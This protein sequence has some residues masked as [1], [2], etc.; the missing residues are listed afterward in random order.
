MN[1]NGGDIIGNFYA[2]YA[3]TGSVSDI[4]YKKEVTPVT[5]GLNEIMRLNPIKYKYNMP[6]ESML[7]NDP[8]FFL[9]FSA[10]EVQG[11]IPEAVHEKMESGNKDG[12]LAITYDELIPV[13][14][15][16]IKEQQVMI[17]NQNIKINKLEA[18]VNQLLNN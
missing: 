9:G 3:V 15:N 8:D 18:L 10:Q 7:A 12:M 16:V 5:Y 17:H 4:R 11:I 6:K 2:I 1:R 14:V 13:L